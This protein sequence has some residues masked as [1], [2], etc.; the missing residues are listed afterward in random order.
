MG[1]NPKDRI[2]GQD[3]RCFAADCAISF[4]LSFT[5]TQRGSLSIV[6]A[7]SSSMK[8]VGNSVSAC[9]VLSSHFPAKPM[10]IP[11]NRE[12]LALDSVSAVK[13]FSRIVAAQ[14]FLISSIS[15]SYPSLR[16]RWMPFSFL[17]PAALASESA[18]NTRNVLFVVMMQY[19]VPKCFGG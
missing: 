6:L 4:A 8:T 3:R 11:S 10:S 15:Q 7:L 2:P 5:N 12:R 16:K 9:S 13:S 1:T 17:R 18:T 14:P 19:I